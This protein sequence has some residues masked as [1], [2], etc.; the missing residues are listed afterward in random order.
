MLGIDDGPF[1]K[2][3][4]GEV[5]IVGVV[6]EGSVL[7]EG[8]FVSSFPVDGE[9]ASEFLIEWISVEVPRFGRRLLSGG[10]CSLLVPP[11]VTDRGHVVQG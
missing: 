1:E 3:Q 10:C 2:G 11:F 9:R 7:I 6:M 8:V 4:D 5:P